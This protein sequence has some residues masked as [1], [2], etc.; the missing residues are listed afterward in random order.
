M[1]SIGRRALHQLFGQGTNIPRTAYDNLIDSTINI[2]DDGLEVDKI[3][4]LTLKA[5]PT[6]GKVI[7]FVGGLNRPDSAW[8]ILMNP[9]RQMGLSISNDQGESM[10]FLQAGGNIGLGTLNPQTKLDVQGTVAAKGWVGTYSE[11]L[12]N[13]DSRWYT[14]MHNLD[15]C[16]GFEAIA[17]IKYD[18]LHA[19]DLT[20]TT[21]L[22]SGGRKGKRIQTKRATLAYGWFWERLR[23]P[24]RFR[25]KLDPNTP[26]DSPPRYLL[27]IRSSRK[28]KPLHNK[29]AMIYF[30]LSKI[31]DRNYEN[32]EERKAY[33]DV[34]TEEDRFP[35]GKLKLGESQVRK[36]A[37][38]KVPPVPIVEEGAPMENRK[39]QVNTSRNTSRKIVRLT[40]KKNPPTQ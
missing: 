7:S 29:Q 24:I 22:I 33:L 2:T 27:Q 14:I 16:Q 37:I 36:S 20:H 31:W 6:S 1:P 9:E 35:S 34:Q 12:V 4:G 13:A 32:L 3:N 40:G 38:P 25:W 30:R 28:L 21:I 18:E 39:P 15:A 19:F 17:H 26:P 11:G 8:S 23:R 5:Q 10:L